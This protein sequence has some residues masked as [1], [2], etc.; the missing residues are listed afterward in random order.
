MEG[1]LAS[2]GGQWASGIGLKRIAHRADQV[3]TYARHARNR[4]GTAL[5]ASGVRGLCAGSGFQRFE[6]CSC[7]VID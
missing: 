7:S 4:C 1:R 5:Q 6:Q 3:L 2:V